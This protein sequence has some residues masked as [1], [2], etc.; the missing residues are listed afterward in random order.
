MSVPKKYSGSSYISK[1]E[2]LGKHKSPLRSLRF[3]DS[4]NLNRKK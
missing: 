3:T 1:L 4:V 2:A